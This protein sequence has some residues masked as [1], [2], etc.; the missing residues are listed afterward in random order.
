MWLI[1]LFNLS[2]QA[3]P[4]LS[5]DDL[6]PLVE[7]NNQ[8]YKAE[9]L[10]KQALELED[11]SLLRSFIPELRAYRELNS[12]QSGREFFVKHPEM[13]AQAKFNLYNQGQDYLQT[14]VTNTNLKNQNSTVSL[15][16]KEQT[17]LAGILYWNLVYYKE[18]KAL[19]DSMIKINEQNKRS[20][21]RRIDSGLATDADRLEFDMT[22]IELK[23]HLKE[24]AFKLKT[25]KQ[26]LALLLGTE[27]FQVP[28]KLVHTHKIDDLIRDND[29]AKEYTEPLKNKYEL[30]KTKNRL[31]KLYW[32]PKIDFNV[33]YEQ[34]DKTIRIPSLNI[35]D[36]LK[37]EVVLS[38]SLTF[39]LDGASRA[40]KTSQA[41]RYKSQAFEAEYNYQKQRREIQLNTKVEKLKLMHHL[42]HEVEEEIELAQDY[43]NLT[44]K[45]YSRGAK[46]SPDM[47]G[48]ANRLYEKNKERLNLIRD[49]HVLKTEYL[50]LI[51]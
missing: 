22:Q 34:Y 33:E 18:M 14:Q 27:S 3:Q 12:K 11:F 21:K 37:S 26:S 28:D 17:K 16:L 4:M 32:T 36:D 31:A 46:N 42:V 51:N 24:I 43:Y 8:H 5:F 1:V 7:K 20:A 30:F 23:H 29:L 2:L 47:L 44:K 35:V 25:L 41:M 15:T 38:L 6:Q 9:R 13:R 49:Y 19:H 48:A 39:D 50:A 40:N 45:E 10:K